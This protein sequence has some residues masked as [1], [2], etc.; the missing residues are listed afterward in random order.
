MRRDAGAQRL[1][2]RRRAAGRAAHQGQGAP[3]VQALAPGVG[4]GALDHA[5]AVVEH[6]V[7]EQAP[8]AAERVGQV[9]RFPARKDAAIVPFLDVLPAALHEVAGQAG[10]HGFAGGADE[11]AELGELG[12]QQAQQLV[13]A[14]F[15]ARVRRGGQ[16]Q[17]VPL[18]IGRQQAQQVVT[19]VAAG[20]VAGAGV[21]LVD[22]HQFRAAV[23]KVAAAAVA[24]DVVEADHRVRVHGE[25]VVG[26]RQAAL[27]PSRAGR[28]DGHRLDVEAVVE[29]LHPLVHQVRRAEHGEAVDL[30]T[31]EQLAGDHAGFDGLADAD[32]VT[33]QQAHD[34]LLQRH[35]QWH[36]LVSARLE[37]VV[38]EAAEGA[39]TAPQRHQQR[40]AQQQGLFVIGRL[41]GGGW[42][43]GGRHHGIV[44]GFQR[45]ANQGHLG[46]TA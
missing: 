42:W 20:I 13:E 3:E 46:F 1:Q 40:I 23:G 4:A 18:L 7:E 24:L 41:R 17:H 14:G 37:G 32:V 25:D 5:G 44:L 30:A 16:E 35:Q 9:S 12:L 39:G 27:Q 36:Q 22:D 31:V 33:N 29:L 34:L 2:G 28:S 21:G 45:W 43:K 8:V 26:E 19:L 6:G 38:A 15:I 10:A 11:G